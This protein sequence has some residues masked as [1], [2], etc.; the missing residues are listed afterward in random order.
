MFQNFD[1]T[2]I[3]TPVNVDVYEQL[4][5]ESSYPIEKRQYLVN[6]FWEGFSLQYQGIKKYTE[7]QTI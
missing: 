2:S 1:L 5:I 3:V 7:Q 6:G 4:L